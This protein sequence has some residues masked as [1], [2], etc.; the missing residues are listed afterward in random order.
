MTVKSELEKLGINFKTIELVE[1]VTDEEVSLEKLK[2]FDNNLRQNGLELIKNHKEILSEKIKTAVIEVVHYSDKQLK[3]NLSYY[4]SKK[5][6]YNY[7]YLANV[8]SELNDISIEKFYISHKIERVKELIVNNELNLKEISFIT[9][10]SSIAHL[11]NQFKKSTGLTPSQYRQLVFKNR[12]PL[13]QIA[14]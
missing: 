10:Y 5:L 7:T 6:N 9:Q 4:L 14:C 2:M 13:E 1:V 12:M 8:F 11:S 3:L